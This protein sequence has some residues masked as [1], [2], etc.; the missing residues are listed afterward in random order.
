[1]ILYL[2]VNHVDLTWDHTPSIFEEIDSR[3]DNNFGQGSENIGGVLD[4]FLHASIL[5]LVTNQGLIV[6]HTLNHSSVS[7]G[8]RIRHT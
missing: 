8:S 5:T 1:M 6:D 7:W 4:D 3:N 2:I